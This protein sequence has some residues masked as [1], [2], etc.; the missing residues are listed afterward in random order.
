MTREEANII[1]EAIRAVTC[2]P[3]ETQYDCG[4]EEIHEPGIK[5]LNAIIKGL[6]KDF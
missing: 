1:F 2:H 5:I 6:M 3:Y 4:P